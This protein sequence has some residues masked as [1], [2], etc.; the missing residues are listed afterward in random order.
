LL[1]TLRDRADD[2]QVQGEGLW[3]IAL[4]VTVV[5]PQDQAAGD[6]A[7]RLAASVAG[8]STRPPYVPYRPV[9]LRPTTRACLTG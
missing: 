5:A 9:D 4:A 6:D 2:D 3:Q 7:Y 8:P 1:A